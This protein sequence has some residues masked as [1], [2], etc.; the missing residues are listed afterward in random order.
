MLESEGAVSRQVQ[1]HEKKGKEKGHAP[2]E[3]EWEHEKE[4]EK[5]VGEEQGEEHRT[6]STQI[7]IWIES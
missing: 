3:C 4:K 2:P 1:G 7:E 5:R 6:R